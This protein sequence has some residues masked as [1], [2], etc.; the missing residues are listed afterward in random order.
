MSASLLG[1]VLIAARRVSLRAA[2]SRLSRS[3]F[4]TTLYLSG[5]LPLSA[6][7]GNAISN[8]GDALFPAIAIAPKAALVATLYSGVP[9]AIVAYGWLFL[10]ELGI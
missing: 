5:A 3:N 2:S 7:F 4:L 6:Q 9:A 10:F 1:T 8:D